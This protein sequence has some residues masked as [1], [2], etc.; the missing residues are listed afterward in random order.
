MLWF[1][2]GYFKRVRT[3]QTFKMTMAIQVWTPFKSWIEKTHTAMISKRTKIVYYIPSFG[4]EPETL[5]FSPFF[6]VRFPP[7]WCHWWARQQSGEIFR[8]SW[9]CGPFLLHLRY[10]S[11][12]K[13]P[14]VGDSWAGIF[15]ETSRLQFEEN[16]PSVCENVPMLAFG[17]ERMIFIL[18]RAWWVSVRWRELLSGWVYSETSRSLASTLSMRVVTSWYDHLEWK[19]FACTG[20]AWGMATGVDSGDRPPF[21]CPNYGKIYLQQPWLR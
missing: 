18:G 7:V 12:P 15:W 2:L 10:S 8:K 4:R 11:W 17:S 1:Q 13:N 14:R 16:P 21:L 5:H 9:G 6:C 3:I 19:A 20:L